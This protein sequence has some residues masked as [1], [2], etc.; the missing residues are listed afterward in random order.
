MHFAL[1][2]IQ[3]TPSKQTGTGTGPCSYSVR[4]LLG[5]SSE[6]DTRALCQR[7]LVRSTNLCVVEEPA[8]WLLKHNYICMYVPCLACRMPKAFSFHVT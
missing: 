6:I 7:S 4:I 3:L 1:Q 8:A 2:G 5:P